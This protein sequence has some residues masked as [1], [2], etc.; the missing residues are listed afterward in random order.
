[1]AVTL[2]ELV[3]VP[4]I[5]RPSDISIIKRYFIENDLEEEAIQTLAELSKS[6]VAKLK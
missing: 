6:K 3:N 4:Y 1:M 2:K 5:E